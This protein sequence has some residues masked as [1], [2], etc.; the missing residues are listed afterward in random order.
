MIISLDV[1]F[2]DETKSAALRSLDIPLMR[3][4]YGAFKSYISSQK[5]GD[6]FFSLGKLFASEI[7]LSHNDLLSGNILYT[8]SVDKQN[9]SRDP[10]TLI[11]YE[12]CGYNYRGYDL[13]NHFCEFCG[14]DF[15]VENNFPS[16]ELRGKFYVHYIRNMLGKSA[17]SDYLSRAV[18]QGLNFEDELCSHR[19]AFLK[20]FDVSPLHTLPIHGKNGSN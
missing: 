3:S 20:G 5:V 12:Y 11:D 1:T 9:L 17:N 18:S 10:I 15:D 6:N 14:F 16:S 13:A 7:V 2:E 8:S 4:Q 19:I